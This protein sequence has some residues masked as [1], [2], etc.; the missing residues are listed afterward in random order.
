MPDSD[1]D[2]SPKE[3]AVNVDVD[4]FCGN[5]FLCGI[6]HLKE[7]KKFKKHVE[8]EKS[9]KS[10]MWGGLVIASKCGHLVGQKCLQTYN[11]SLT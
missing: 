11:S 3:Q 10:V 1:G 6:E 4:C 8:G 5:S 2:I 9:K 7:R